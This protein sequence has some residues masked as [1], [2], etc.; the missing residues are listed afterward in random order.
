MMI[1]VY[2]VGVGSTVRRQYAHDNLRIVYGGLLLLLLTFS[3][4][5][6]PFMLLTSEVSNRNIINAIKAIIKAIK[7]IKAIINAI[8]EACYGASYRVHSFT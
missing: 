4:F 5:H 1:Q 8:I 2:D 7:A 6:G 3:Q